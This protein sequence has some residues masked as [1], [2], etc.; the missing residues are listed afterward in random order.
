MRHRKKGRCRAAPRHHVIDRARANTKF[1]Q[2]PLSG[3]VLTSQIR[4]V[5]TDSALISRRVT[6]S[7]STKLNYAWLRANRGDPAYKG[8]W[9]ALHAGECVAT[10][11]SLKALSTKVEKLQLDDVLFAQC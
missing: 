3:R 1:T 8:L 4:V 6:K 5:C 2:R 10:D 9:V 7:E 11:K